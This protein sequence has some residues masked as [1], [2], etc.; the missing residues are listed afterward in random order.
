MKD[1]FY[2]RVGCILSLT[3]CQLSWSMGAKS[4]IL[5]ATDATNAPYEMRD[6][7]G[8][9]I[10][11]D[12]DIIKAIAHS[13]NLD[14]TVLPHSWGSIFE[15]INAGEKDVIV[16]PLT[17]TEERK[18]LVDF[19][20]PYILPTRT[21][22]MKP[23]VQQA[24]GINGF[25]DLDKGK[26]AAKGQTTNITALEEF[27]GK[28]NPNIVSVASQY[29]AFKDM[30]SGAVDSGFGDTLV[31]KY[32]A[33]FVQNLP[34]V[35]FEQP[36]DEPVY[37]GFAVRKGNSSLKQT[38]DQGILDIISSGV[39]KTLAVK[40]FG[41][42]EGAKFTNSISQELLSNNGGRSE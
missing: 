41:E 36:L 35:A 30:M 42:I 24:L 39:Y 15:A 26:I 9:L 4:T 38:L 22:L 21:A 11:F 8:Q 40:W 25:Y 5:A 29:L 3:F 28:D 7:K 6:E 18:K 32:H 1:Y 34:L 33:S 31:L 19:T 20:I 16:A 12:V 27:F 10:G 13:Q 37:A 23:E 17:I 14:V 2:L